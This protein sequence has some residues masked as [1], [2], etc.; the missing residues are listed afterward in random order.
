M[1]FDG[2]VGYFTAVL[3]KDVRLSTEPSTR[4]PRLLEW[5]PVFFPTRAPFTCPTTVEIARRHGDGRVWYEW[6]VH[7]DGGGA[8]DGV[9]TGQCPRPDVHNAGGKWCW[10]G[11]DVA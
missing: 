7:A 8:S 1:P 9:I 2:L 4:T 10:M 6:A 11:T 3:Y 5:L